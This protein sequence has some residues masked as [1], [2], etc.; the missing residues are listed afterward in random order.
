MFKKAADL[1]SESGEKRQQLWLERG[2][3]ATKEK[4]MRDIARQGL[5]QDRVK[6]SVQTRVTAL[7]QGRLSPSKDRMSIAA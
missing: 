7:L 4:G 6:E 3:G 2:L 1:G 5:V